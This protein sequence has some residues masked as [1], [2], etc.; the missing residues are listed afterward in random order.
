MDLMTVVMFTL[1]GTIAM[2]GSRPGERDAAVVTRL[3]GA[4]LVADVPGLA[5]LGTDLD[6]R[7][8]RAV[9]SADLTYTQ[10]LDLARAASAAIT[11]GAQGI[12]VTQGTDTL[13]ET[14]YLLDLVWPHEEP[15][16]L[17]GAM[18]NPTLA[19]PD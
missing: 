2:N 11:Q 17:T 5:D 13:E 12:I 18:R 3:S 1:G 10:I 14:A 19:G 16:V 15:I 9:P 6:V 8:A 7:D 4:D